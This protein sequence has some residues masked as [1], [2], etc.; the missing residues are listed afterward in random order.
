LSLRTEYLGS[1]WMDESMRN[2]VSTQRPVALFP[3]TDPSA[4]CFYR[5]AE[6]IEYLF[7]QASTPK[8]A[9]SEYWQKVVENQHRKRLQTSEP[10]KP[11]LVSNDSVPEMQKPEGH[12]PL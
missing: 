6:S 2:A 1:V 12:E 4:R 3:K 8:L 11:E 10:K 5:M 7:E 9:F